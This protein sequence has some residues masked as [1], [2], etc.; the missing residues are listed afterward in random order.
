MA[1]GEVTMAVITGLAV[2]PIHT[3]L[4]AEERA[5]FVTM[6]RDKAREV[7]L[8]KPLDLGERL[9]G[10]ATDAL[11][12]PV[13][14]VLGEV[15]KQR[16]EM[17]DVA[18]KTLGTPGKSAEVELFEHTLDWGVHPTVTVTVNSV[19]ATLELHV[20]VKLKLEGAKLVIE[21]ARITRF[22]S[23]TVTSTLSIKFRDVEVTAPYKGKWDLPGQVVL[24][25]GGINLSGVSS[26]ASPVS[27]E[28]NGVRRS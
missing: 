2:D 3:G 20:M 19:S 21:R 7:A 12:K 24:P 9:L 15:W 1:D 13:A 10:A 28:A 16:K 17:R 14:E 25:R 26:P 4:S 11:K 5:R 27:Q 8:L 23:G 18:D 6:L 22:L